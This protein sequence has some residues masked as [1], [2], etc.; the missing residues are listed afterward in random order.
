MRND[1][2]MSTRDDDAVNDNRA[3]RE[4]CSGWA[5]VGGVEP[6]SLMFACRR[7]RNSVAPLYQRRLAE[8][9]DTHTF[10]TR[11]FFLR[12]HTS[13]INE[14]SLYVI[15]GSAPTVARASSVLCTP[16]HRQLDMC[17][18]GEG[19]SIR[20][21][22]RRSEARPWRGLWRCAVQQVIQLPAD[23][24]AYRSRRR[25]FKTRSDKYTRSAVP[26][27]VRR[28]REGGGC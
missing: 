14:G 25:W 8:C 16:L 11:G 13:S 20:R 12:K 15:K 2:G 22:K 21:N 17:V 4:S 6:V 10:P 27:R 3:Q 24:N 19:G 7:A 23:G 18:V 9:P 26:G 28:R 1:L 5:I